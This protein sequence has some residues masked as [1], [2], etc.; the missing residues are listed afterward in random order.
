[1]VFF[2]TFPTKNLKPPL[3]KTETGA[4]F[5]FFYIM[6]IFIKQFRQMHDDSDKE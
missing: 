1:M 3:S 2:V 5:F 4:V 6:I